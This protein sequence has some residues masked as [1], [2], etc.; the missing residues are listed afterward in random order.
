MFVD[1]R[2]IPGQPLARCFKTIGSTGN[3]YTVTVSPQHGIAC[4]CIDAKMNGV[5]SCKHCLYVKARVLKIPV[6]NPL[7][8][9]TWFS[10]HQL[11]YIYAHAPDP[12]GVLASRKIRQAYAKASGFS[13]PADAMAGEDEEE[14][15]GSGSGSGAVLQRGRQRSDPAGEDCVICFD[16]LGS[17]FGQLTWC[18]SCGNNIHNGCM[19]HWIAT[20][21]KE[22]SNVTCPV[23]RATWREPASLNLHNAR[24]PSAAPPASASGSGSGSGSGS[25]AAASYVSP[26]RHQS[27]SYTNSALGGSSGGGGGFG[28]PFST[29]P[30]TDDEIARALTP[31]RFVPFRAPRPSIELEPAPK[32]SGAGSGGGKGKGKGRTRVPAAARAVITAVQASQGDDAVQQFLQTELLGQASEAAQRRKTKREQDKQKKAEEE[33]KEKEQGGGNEPEEDEEAK[34]PPRKRAKKK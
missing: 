28:S 26:A 15:D 22:H 20:K 19:K 23:C 25:A 11:E 10:V 32:D 17:D 29:N 31:G 1:R 16:E 9:Q 21:K 7:I 13:L 4:D 14:E 24:P 18:V 2:D 33:A 3:V 34:R 8:Y 5:G 12:G 30:M 6:D 27:A